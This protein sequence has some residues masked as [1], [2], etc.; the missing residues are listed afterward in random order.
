MEKGEKVIRADKHPI[1]NNLNEDDFG[2]GECMSDDMEEEGVDNM[3]RR[4]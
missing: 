3:V 4:T 1:Q 2:L